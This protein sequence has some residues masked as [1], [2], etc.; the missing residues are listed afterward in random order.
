MKTLVEPFTSTSGWATDGT[1]TFGPVNLVPE[2]IAD[3]LAGSL[4]VHIPAGSQGKTFFKTVGVTITGYPE[5]VFSVWSRNKQGNGFRK[6]T[7]FYYKVSFDAGATSYYVPTF[8]NFDSV[9]IA[10]A[11][12][13]S[14]VSTLIFT[15]LHNDEDWLCLSAMNAVANEY[16]L[17]IF[18]AVQND[19]G[20]AAAAIYPNGLPTGDTLTGTLGDST[21]TF[22]GNHDFLGRYRLVKI[23]DGVHSEMHIIEEWGEGTATFKSSWDGKTLLYSYTA[24]AVYIQFPVSITLGETDLMLP[25]LAIDGMHPEHVMR[26]SEVGRIVDT[27]DASNNGPF[28]ERQE[29]MLLRFPVLIDV[30]AQEYELLARANRIVRRFL[31]QGYLWINARK[32]DFIFDQAPVDVEPDS[33]NET[34]PKT[35]YVLNVEVREPVADRLS[36]ARYV[37]YTASWTIVR[38]GVSL[39]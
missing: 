2:F 35:Q 31:S 26:T 14:T 32:H 4:I 1:I 12:P 9:T 33:V 6:Y 25:V 20:I 38:Q 18:A 24:A 28:M 30:E 17:D 22:A 16:P 3:R 23:T 10:P 36:S 15:V 27:F 5:L 19:L 37:S 34:L 11:T 29:D 7:D 39:P 21:V 13:L 8:P